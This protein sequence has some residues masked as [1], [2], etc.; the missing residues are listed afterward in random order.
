MVV[1]QAIVPD[2]QG[3]WTK[4]EVIVGT[5]IAILVVLL[6]DKILPRKRK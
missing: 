6:L 4:T 5:V 1:A 2:L 3:D